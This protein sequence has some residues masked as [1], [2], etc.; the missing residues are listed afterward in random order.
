MPVSDTINQVV[1]ETLMIPFAMIVDDELREC[2]DAPAP[3]KG[4]SLPSCAASLSVS[5]TSGIGA[6]SGVISTNRCDTYE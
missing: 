3:T 1:A 6:I 5:G 4:T 2:F